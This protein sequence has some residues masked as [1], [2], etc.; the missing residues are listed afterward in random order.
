MKCFL[1]SC[2]I[3]KSDFSRSDSVQINPFSNWISP[4]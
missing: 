4:R 1:R 3:D 2:Y